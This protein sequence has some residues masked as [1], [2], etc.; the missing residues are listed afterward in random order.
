M[1]DS[2]QTSTAA[3]ESIGNVVLPP[4]PITAEQY[5]QLPDLVYPTELVR[6]QIKLMEYPCPDHGQIC[7]TFGALLRNYIKE[8][9][10]GGHQ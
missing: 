7:A 10:V 1:S 8:L 2:T 4:G 6:G 5:G 3:V 9:G